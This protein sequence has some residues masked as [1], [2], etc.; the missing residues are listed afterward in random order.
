MA[1]VKQP[2]QR[3]TLSHGL[4]IA[5]CLSPGAYIPLVMRLIKKTNFILFLFFLLSTRVSSQGF[6]W[7]PDSITL[8]DPNFAMSH[9]HEVLRHHDPVMYIVFPVIKPMVDRKVPLLDGEG[10]DGF[11]VE[12]HF[13]YRF[14]IYQG[15]YYSI[16]FFQRTRFTLDVSIL[17]RL[18]MAAWHGP[19]SNF[20][21][22]PTGRRIAFFWKL[23]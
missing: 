21:I 1:P 12:G 3:F 23:R 8:A 10:K 9:Y 15:K 2:W 13:G 6:I 19:R 16:P 22:I 11:W 17:S 4:K 18:N 14:T 5:F 20:I 7:S